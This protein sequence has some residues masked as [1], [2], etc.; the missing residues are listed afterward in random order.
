MSLEPNEPPQATA[1]HNGKWVQGP[2]TP[3]QLQCFE[4]LDWARQSP[5]VHEHPGKY[6]VVHKKRI[7]AV[8]DDCGALLKQAALQEQC[9]S[10]ELAVEVVPPE[11]VFEV[12]PSS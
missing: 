7:I 4:D 1:N 8:G 5:E 12:T 10:W 6:V 9:P 11:E 3:Q 2:L